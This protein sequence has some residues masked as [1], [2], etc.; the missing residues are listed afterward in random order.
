MGEANPSVKFIVSHHTKYEMLL[1]LVGQLERRYC[2]SCK[3]DGA[4]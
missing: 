3:D 2:R 4:V 1:T